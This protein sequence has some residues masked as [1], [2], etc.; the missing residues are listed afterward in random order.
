MFAPFLQKAGFGFRQTVPVLATAIFIVLGSL[1]WPIPY[2][3]AVTPALGLVAIYYWAMY[4]PDL[5]RPHLVFFLGLLS[6]VVEYLPLG[7]TALVYVGVYELSV[8]QRR[9]F[10]GQYFPMLW[11]GF[12]IVCVLAAFTQWL[13][14][15]LTGDYM[16]SVQPVFFQTLMTIA[17]FPLPVWALNKVQKLFLTSETD[18]A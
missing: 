10:L 2:V 14:L 12:F 9:Y 16:M 15:S 7:L 17:L 8:S 1:V 5:M 4:R 13:F 3:G 18:V 6:D 11:A